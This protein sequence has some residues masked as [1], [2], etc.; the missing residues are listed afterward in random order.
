MVIKTPSEQTQKLDA[1]GLNQVMKKTILT[2]LTLIVLTAGI[3]VGLYHLIYH[4]NLTSNNYFD[5]LTV[6]MRRA[7][8]ITDIASM[9][10]LPIYM[11]INLIRLIYFK[12]LKLY[13]TLEMIVGALVWVT[14]LLLHY[15]LLGS[16]VMEP[17]KQGWTVY[18]PLSGLPTQ[19][20]DTEPLRL[21]QEKN[22]LLLQIAIILTITLFLTVVTVK[23]RKKHSH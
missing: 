23:K 21:E 9:F 6:E 11:A 16:A 8:L 10:F 20:A 3:S 12:F 14:I 15:Y 19:M 4:I 2:E 17:A 5:M 7:S 18:P 13:I 22:V 1:A